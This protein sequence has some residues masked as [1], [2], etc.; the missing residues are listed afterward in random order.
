[1]A[2]SLDPS[3]VTRTRLG[4]LGYFRNFWRSRLLKIAPNLMGIKVRDGHGR[5]STA[6]WETD[7]ILNVPGQCRGS[8]LA[9]YMLTP[10]GIFRLLGKNFSQ[11]FF[12]A[13]L[14]SLTLLQCAKVS[15]RILRE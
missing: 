9:L 7:G 5:A 14:L 15:R 6:G 2:R 1:M 4:T 12:L 11:Y 10:T 8:L 13:R 3:E